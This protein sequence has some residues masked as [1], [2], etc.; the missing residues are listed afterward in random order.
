MFS[1]TYCQFSSLRVYSVVKR[2][3]CIQIKL[4]ITWSIEYYPWRNGMY[5]LFCRVNIEINLFI[6]LFDRW[7]DAFITVYEFYTSIH[8]YNVL[9]SYSSFHYCLLFI[10]PPFP[11]LVSYLQHFPL[12]IMS[13][14]LLQLRHLSASMQYIFVLCEWLISLNIVISSS[15]LSKGHNFIPF[16]WIKFHCVYTLCFLYLSFC[17]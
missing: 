17:W 13:S 14:S 4:S 16:G 3:V 10:I 15:F 5:C 7:N 6:P 2:L 9:W 8:A 1:S 11:L 12:L